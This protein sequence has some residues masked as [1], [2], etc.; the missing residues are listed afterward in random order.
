MNEDHPQNEDGAGG[1]SLT[2]NVQ[3]STL[4]AHAQGPGSHAVG[5]V[6][7]YGLGYADV[8]AIVDEKLSA[9]VKEL[10]DAIGQA[11]DRN[12]EEMECISVAVI[13]SLVAAKLGAPPDAAAIT[14][15]LREA[16][17]DPAFPARAARLFLEAVKTPST[18]RRRMLARALF[19]IPASTPERDRVDAALERLF[20]DDVVLLRTL[21]N[22][23]HKRQQDHL[24]I[25]KTTGGRVTY[26]IDGDVD[27]GMGRIVKRPF[28]CDDWCLHALQAVA[29]I[30]F[31]TPPGTPDEWEDYTRVNILPLGR[32]VLKVLEDV[33]LDASR[34]GGQT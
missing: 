2:S 26:A 10:R 18:T 21:D 13:Q 22:W 31:G 8:R 17:E 16:V 19:G 6:N 3:G 15:F 24:Y 23:A 34:P 4:A 7:N 32:A 29:C 11:S 1:A 12:R 5:I 25:E 30:S 33:E 28:Q 9:T 20:P 27:Q 14:Q